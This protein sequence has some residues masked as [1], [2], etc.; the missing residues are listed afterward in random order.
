MTEENL[1]DGQTKQKG[2]SDDDHH[3]LTQVELAKMLDVSVTTVQ[4]MRKDPGFPKRKRF[5]R[6]QKGWIKSEVKQWLVT[7]PSA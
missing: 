4:R 6:S 2:G 1:A 7:C 3:I 5:T